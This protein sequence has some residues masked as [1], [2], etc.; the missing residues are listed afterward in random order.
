MMYITLTTC[1]LQ[2]M[3]TSVFVG[4]VGHLRDYGTRH[5]VGSVG[6]LYR[7]PGIFMEHKIEITLIHGKQLA[8]FNFVKGGH[9]RSKEGY[10]N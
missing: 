4:E 9:N 6:K 7:C 5:S 10:V 1:D 3:H 2:L 8:G